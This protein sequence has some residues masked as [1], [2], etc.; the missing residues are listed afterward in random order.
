[1]AVK[2]IISRAMLKWLTIDLARYLLGLDAE[3]AKLLETQHQRIGDPPSRFS[4][5]F[6]PIF[7]SQRGGKRPDARRASTGI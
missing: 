6:H 4:T 7:R 3:A 1:M 2:D 5:P